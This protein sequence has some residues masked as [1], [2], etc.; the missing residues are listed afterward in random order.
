MKI[1]LDPQIFYKQSFGG[2]S[3]LFT[4]LLSRYKAF[5]DDI[6]IECPLPFHQNIHLM[7]KGLLKPTFF[8]KFLVDSKFRGVERLR[9]IFL[10]YQQ[11]TIARLKSKKTTIFIPT[12]YDDYY[13]DFLI[14]K[15]LVLTVHDMTS[16]RYPDF[17]KDVSQVGIHKKTLMERADRIVV[18]SNNTKKDILFYYP[19]IEEEKIR[20]IHLSQSIDTDKIKKLENVPKKYILF[21]GNRYHYK[22]YSFF[23]A[24]ISQLLQNTADL[25]VVCAGGG[26]FEEAEKKQ[27][28][29]LG[30]SDQVLQYDFTDDE[31]GS[32]YA[33]AQLFVFPSLYEGFGIPV[34]EAMTCGCPIVLSNQSSFPEVAGDAGIFFEIGNSQDLLTKVETVLNNPDFRQKYIDAG[35]QR[36]KMF[37]WDKTVH[38]YVDV[39][40]EVM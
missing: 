29:E 5:G 10:S 13:V 19:H 1:L 34:L 31:L 20:V 14:G 30:L 22:N 32:Y 38:Q 21:V 3:R 23:I 17:F 24:A 8:N 2:I 35:L 26:E 16:E 4:E 11:Q 39:L 6:T 37:S 27:L 9:R 25:F 12:F 15:K 28:S 36:S 7:D 33:N 40:K 18:V